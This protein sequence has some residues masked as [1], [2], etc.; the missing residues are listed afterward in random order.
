MTNFYQSLETAFGSRLDAPALILRDRP[1]W[2]F[3]QLVSV[4]DRFLSLIHI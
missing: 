2:D 3:Q 1:D 4:V